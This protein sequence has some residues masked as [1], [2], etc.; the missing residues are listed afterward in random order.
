MTIPDDEWRRRGVSYWRSILNQVLDQTSTT[1]GDKQL[2]ELVKQWEQPGSV[3][4][5]KLGRRKIGSRL[6]VQARYS[7]EPP[8][9]EDQEAPKKKPIR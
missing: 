8:M 7:V 2:S 6:E 4:V 5:L 3:F 1:A 9:F